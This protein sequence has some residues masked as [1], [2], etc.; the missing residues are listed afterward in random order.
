[1]SDEF[2]RTTLGDIASFTNGKSLS[3]NRYGQTG[4][5]EVYGSNGRLGFTD[6]ALFDEPTVIIGRVG[7]N[8][9]VV[10]FAEGPAWVTDN[11]IAA[12]GDGVDDQFLYYLLKNLELNRLAT[13]SAQPLVTQ[14]ALKG[15]DVKIPSWSNQRA[16]ASMLAAF[17]SRIAV[18]H[19]MNQ[20]LESIAR[21]IF[22]S[23]FIDF[24]PVVAKS[25][26]RAPYGMDADSIAVRLLDG[27]TGEPYE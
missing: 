25:E 18:N 2:C 5:Y 21:T 6:E 22:K 7:A 11:A 20:T 16:I 12:Q 19:R 13:G 10:H 9:G 27:S 1:M 17:D 14:T 26:G 4:R 3:P 15:V 23:W 8:C 24:D